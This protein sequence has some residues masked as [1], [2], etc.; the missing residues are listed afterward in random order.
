M[1]TS[2]A[3]DNIPGS[4]KEAEKT[5]KKGGEEKGK[6][7]LTGS[8]F[9]PVLRLRHLWNGD[10]GVVAESSEEVGRGEWRRLHHVERRQTAQSPTG[11]RVRP[12]SKTTTHSLQRNA[13]CLLMIP[14]TETNKRL[15]NAKKPCGF[16]VLCLRP[17]SSLCSCPHGPH[18]GRIV[19]F[20]LSVTIET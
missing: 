9:V 12:A 13:S 18:Y 16:S 17:K 6:M 11:G 20:S 14:T 19:V 4:C 8:V 10:L 15:A 2:K 3:E 1:M 7:S 5:G